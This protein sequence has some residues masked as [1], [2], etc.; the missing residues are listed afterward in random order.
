MSWTVQDVQNQIAGEIDQSDTAPSQG[1]TDW[2]L[3]LNAMNRSIID[4]ANSNDWDSLKVVHN[5]KVS[6]GGGASY[7][8]PTNFVKM[9]SFPRIVWDGSSLDEFPVVDPSTN[10][11]Y[12]DS[13]H[14]VNLF[15][16]D[17]DTKVMYIHSNT[18]SSGAS[19][20]FTY[21][22]SP[23]SLA[24]AGDVIDVPD[25]TYVVQRTLYYIYKGREDGR[26]PEAKVEADR[27]LARMLENENARGLAY[28]D[29]TIPNELDSKFSFRIGRD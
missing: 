4:W 23:Q 2:N 28:K 18:L 15:I 21:Y 16:N 13:D 14:F 8:L 29:R 20:Q 17:R 27:I 7:V 6:V 10:T 5:G 19:V 12:T 22:K 9:D 11:H 26:F 24:S 25:P 1:D 3:R